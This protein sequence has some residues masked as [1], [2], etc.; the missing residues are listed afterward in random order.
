GV[1]LLS[2]P[3]A[4][5]RVSGQ[6]LLRLNPG[7]RLS[8]QGLDLTM[9][10]DAEGTL[11]MLGQRVHAEGQGDGDAPW[12]AWLLSQPSI[13]LHDATLRWR[14]ESRG[15]PDLVF[16]HVRAVL[17]GSVPDVL[18]AAFSMR[19]PEAMGSAFELRARFEEPDRVAQGLW[20]RAYRLF[21]SIDGM[22][23]AAWRPWAD[24]PQ[25]LIEGRVSLNA[26]AEGD[27][28]DSTAVNPRLTLRAAIDGMD[29]TQSASTRFLAP[30]VRLFAQGPWQGWQSISGVTAGAQQPLALQIQTEGLDLRNP[31]W[32]QHPIA[33]GRLEAQATL[34]GGPQPS[35]ALERLHW[36]NADI[37]VQV[38][39]GWQ[40][41]GHAGQIDLQGTIARARLAAIHRYLPLEVS[42][43]AREWLS[44][45]L[46]RGILTDARLR[47][48]G[49]LAS[50]P[51]GDDPRAG[52]FLIAGDFQDAIIDYIPAEAGQPA[53]PML[54]DLQGRAELH[55][56]TLTLDADQALMRPSQGSAIRLSQLHAV[57]PNI[58]HEAVLTVSGHTQAQGA[59][60]MALIQHTPL[61]GLLDGLFDD[62]QASG[63]WQVPLTLTIPLLH[64][65]DTQVDG[66]I[67]LDDATLQLMPAIPPFQQMKGGLHFTETGMVADPSLK[68][69][70]LGGAA[71]LTGQLGAQGPGFAL[72][73]QMTAQALSEF[74]D[75]PGMSRITGVL[76]YTLQ[77]GRNA[78]GYQVAFNSDL[79]GLGLDLPAPLA[80]PASQARTLKVLWSNR[81][82][83]HDS[84]Q[85]DLGA[86]VSV[87]L[88][89]RRGRRAGPYFQSASLGVGHAPPEP[90]DGLTVD[91]AYALLDMDV[92]KDLLDEFS[93]AVKKDGPDHKRPG[94]P[95][96]EVFPELR[97]LSVQADQ[98][99]LLGLDMQRAA[100][101]VV[102]DPGSG[103]WSVNVR[104]DQTTGTLKWQQGGDG[105]VQGHVSARFARLSLGAEGETGSSLLPDTPT[106]DHTFDDDLDIPAILLQADELRIY[107]HPVGRLAL[108]GVKDASTGNWRLQSLALG[109]E[110]AMVKGSGLWRLRGGRQRG[111]SLKAK[112]EVQDLG[113]WLE[114]AGFHDVMAGGKGVLEGSFEWHDLP[115]TH[116]K[117]KLKGDL[118]V[119]LDKGR[120]SKLGSQSAKLLE[121][122]SLQSLA[123]LARL[124]QTLTGLTKEGFPFDQLRGSLE[125]SDGVVH[126]RDYKV[127]GPVGTILLEGKTNIIHETFD[128]QAVIV[129][130]LDVSGAAIAAGIAIN[131]V[132]GI[133]AFLSQWLLKSPLAK[134]MTVRYHVTGPWDDPVV[135][136]INSG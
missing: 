131:P 92:W 51:F 49:D 134:A 121:L 17:D 34:H 72:K 69:Q 67:L 40:A 48:K 10:R 123:R 20:P 64:S 36:R 95:A 133:G 61:G 107:G 86:D 80:K 39:G 18:S 44:T 15:A 53:W 82:R 16:S 37:D 99:R 120:F 25:A 83:H 7:L 85:I 116:Q 79:Q 108:D 28:D 30:R 111:L 19:P 124:D 89:H 42:A 9:R 81:A 100:L 129:P 103:Q 126:A 47:L 32:F 110:L 98:L 65:H 125:L 130:N 41:G 90:A 77:V 62:A 13:A 66:R 8:V 132:I 71:T 75:L 96:L 46:R 113:G 76:P 63:A 104:S 50:F 38:S 35:M 70:V 21:A 3:Q 122:L 114:G 91:I 106:Q 128:L 93:G 26:W 118:N 24:V 58:E 22:Q 1:T 45:G 23:P 117:V 105:K 2:V 57:I 74:V 97:H 115:W 54:L 109:N 136:E 6:S 127:I 135:T 102:H 52:D 14:D 33:L 11:H 101:R 94:A 56:A 119:A 5:A 55:R 60:Y 43:E 12:L 59:D 78:Q 88:L 73:G 68:L 4:R 87:R 112:A 29:W 27:A 84:L 31:Q